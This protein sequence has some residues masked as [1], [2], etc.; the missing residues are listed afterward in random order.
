MK[1]ENEYEVKEVESKPELQK[2][3]DIREVE[4]TMPTDLSTKYDDD[5]DS[6]PQDSEENKE[7]G[8]VLSTSL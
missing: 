6:P 1:D 3:E 8:V 5:S 7:K 4:K 2:E